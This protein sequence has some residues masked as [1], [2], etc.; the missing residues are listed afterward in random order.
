MNTPPVRRNHRRSR[1]LG[2]V[3]T[4][5][6]LLVAACS[7]GSNPDPDGEGAVD[8]APPSLVGEYELIG[9]VDG[10]KVSGD[11]TVTLTLNDDGTLA[12]KAVQPGETLEDTG[13]WTV[14]DTD[15]HVETADDN[16]GGD[17]PYELRGDILVLPFLVF[18][19]GEGQSEWKRISAPV[20][21]ED[22]DEE[23]AGGTTGGFDDTWVLEGPDAVGSAVGMNAYSEALNDGMAP[24]EAVQAAL[25]EVRAL[26]SVDSAEVSDNGLNIEIVYD[27]GTTD[28]VLTER[29]LAADEEVPSIPPADDEGSDGSGGSGG[30]GASNLTGSSAVAD[31]LGAAGEV[32]AALAPA[33]LGAPDPSSCAKLPSS[34]TAPM[35][36]T[37]EGIDPAGGYGVFA[38][39]PVGGPKPIRSDDSPPA[40]ERTALMVSPQYDVMHAMGPDN[41]NSIRGQAGSNIECIEAS[42]EFRGYDIVKILGKD[43]DFD[44]TGV[45]AAAAF[46]DAL[47]DRPGIVYFLGHGASGKNKNYL[48]MGPVD[49]TLEPITKITGEKSVKIDRDMAMRINEALT[50]YLGLKWDP[51]NMVLNISPDSQN[52]VTL[53]LHPEFFRAVKARGASFDN[54]LVWLNACSSAATGTFQDAIQAKAFV[55]WKQDM[56]GAFIAD[57]SESAFDSLTDS[58]RTARAAVQTWQLHELWEINRGTGSDSSSLDP[59][60]LWGGGKSTEY[61]P[62]TGQT[63]VLLFF[64]RHAP[65]TAAADLASNA[66]GVKGC[67]DQWWAGGQRAALG[68]TCQD[69]QMPGALPTEYE[70]LEAM[71]EAGADAPGA[72]G[73]AAGRWT[74]VD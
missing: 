26:D 30:S 68:T 13:S 41:R 55:G 51:D 63:H 29:L 39:L 42:L 1:S 28:V 32:A 8:E 3:A 40:D 11:A 23:E 47:V 70:V 60:N 72:P 54:S 20:T 2:A 53:W 73:A 49:M 25:S 64:I 69:L 17:G 14:T 24:A 5:V 27:D 48:N 62:L 45:K 71:F 9:D 57:A 18:G 66:Q 33:A 74:L 59:L 6:M 19:D 34:G 12:L 46:I 65:G 7:S 16:I 37:R 52:V 50:K 4:V 61:L 22:D 36:T 15:I 10:T 67:Y 21:T 35:E 56:A 58:T 31:G 38:Y 44:S 43:G